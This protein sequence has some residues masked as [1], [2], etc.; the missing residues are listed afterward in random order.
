MLR[1]AY[2]LTIHKAENHALPIGA[3]Y[4]QAGLTAKVSNVNY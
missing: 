1:E 2:G 4:S 3:L